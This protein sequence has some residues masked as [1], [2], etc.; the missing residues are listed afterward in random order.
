MDEFS[1][2]ISLKIVN[3]LKNYYSWL[4]YFLNIDTSFN[5]NPENILSTNQTKLTKLTKLTYYNIF[6]FTE[7]TLS[8]MV[9]SRSLRSSILT[10]VTTRSEPALKTA[11]WATL[12]A[13]NSSSGV[14]ASIRV[15]M[16]LKWY[17]IPV[18]SNA[19]TAAATYSL[20]LVPGVPIGIIVS[21]ADI[22]IVF[23]SRKSYIFYENPGQSELQPG[24]RNK[25]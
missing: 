18:A 17:F 24:N 11:S 5:D 3:S 21:S 10:L 14:S 13:S 9:R 22:I 7:C 15:P 1:V 12:M 25:S 6:S 2:F 23:M 8:A 16:P 4:I 20:K 19:D